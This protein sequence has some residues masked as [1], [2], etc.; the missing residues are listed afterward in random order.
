MSTFSFILKVTLFF[1]S[2]VFNKMFLNE[3]KQQQK[4]RAALEIF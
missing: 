1:N 2:F 4:E 3:V